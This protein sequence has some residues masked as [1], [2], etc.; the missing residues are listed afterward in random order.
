LQKGAAAF[1]DAREFDVFLALTRHNM[2]EHGEAM[3][4]LLQHIADHSADA[5]T[6]KY[7]RA[8]SYYA[9]HLDPP[10]ED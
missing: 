2:G 1:P 3:R 5:D 10:Y 7:R 4:L 9:E 6:Q 8:I